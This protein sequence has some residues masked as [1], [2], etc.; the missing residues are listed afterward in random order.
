MRCDS[1]VAAPVA[2]V[3]IVSRLPVTVTSS[4]TLTSG[5]TAFTVE[6]WAAE[7]L[8]TASTVWNPASSNLR[9]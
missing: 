6:A 4:A 7:T 5:I 8:T 1:Y 9:V 2:V 3:E